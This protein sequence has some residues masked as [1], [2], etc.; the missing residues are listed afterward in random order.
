MQHYVPR[1]YLR[2]FAADT[3]RSTPMVHC[4]DKPGGNQF[5]T[6]IT[7]I[8]GENYFYDI[9]ED[10]D[11]EFESQL[12]AIEG[13]F[14]QAYDSL[15][16]SE[17]LDALDEN[18]RT[19]IAYSI[20]VQEL[21]TRENRE[22]L[23]DMLSKLCGELEEYPQTDEMAEQ[24]EELRELGTEEGVSRFQR[25]SI[26]NNAWDLAE[27]ILGMKWIL[28][29][30]EISIPY[31]TSDHPIVRHNN[32]DHSP[33]GNLGLR[34]KGIQ[35]YFPLSSSISLAFCDSTLFG[36]LQAKS[37]VDL[38]HVRF[39]NSLQVREST[40]HVIANTDD[41]SMAEAFLDD[42]PEYAQRDRDRVSIE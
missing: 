15:L 1:F 32:I 22:Q 23:R 13:E 3:S 31:W 2:N 35:M 28:L 24:I 11:Q 6:S 37:S 30:N 16:D 18:D 17:D 40:R 21:R 38:D 5:P 19:A 29:M 42:Y 25:R 9:P 8:G 12:S 36:H 33:Y 4:F 26:K 39:Q 10:P 27:I 14:S 20:A 7:N 34:T 41:F